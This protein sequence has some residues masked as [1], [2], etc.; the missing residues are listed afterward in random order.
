MQQSHYLEGQF[1]ISMPNMTDQRFDQSVVYLF[2]HNNDGAMGIVINKIFPEVN[3]KKIL[4]ELN[5]M[6]SQALIDINIHYGGPVE[7]ERGF[8]LHSTECKNISSLNANNISIT[9]SIKIITDLA[10]GNG[11]ENNIF[12]LGYAG[13]GPGQLE[14]ELSKNA[15]INTPYNKEIMFDKDIKSKRQRALETIGVNLSKLSSNVG[16]A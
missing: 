9:S 8:V 15:W 7:I 10:N 5:I 1:L 6:S 3:F 14:Y 12:V 2:L 16:N 13:W 4:S 11:P